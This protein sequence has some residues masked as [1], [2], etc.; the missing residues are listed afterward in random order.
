VIHIYVSHH[1]RLSN[2]HHLLKKPSQKSPRL[3]AGRFCNRSTEL[4]YTYVTCH[5]T[6]LSGDT[7]TNCLLLAPP[8]VVHLCVLPQFSCPAISRKDS[9]AP[10]DPRCARQ[11]DRVKVLPYRLK[12]PGKM[13][14]IEEDLDVSASILLHFTSPISFH[15]RLLVGSL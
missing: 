10:N 7:T 6:P 12:I 5:F 8:R 3:T 13:H 1:L 15:I 2:T 14:E 9:H 11:K 4:A